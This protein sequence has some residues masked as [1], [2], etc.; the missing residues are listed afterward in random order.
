LLAKKLDAK[1]RI[2]VPVIVRGEEE[3]GVRLWQFGKLVYEMADLSEGNHLIDLS[4]LEEGVYF[5]HPS[6][7]PKR[8][9][10]GKR[11]YNKVKKY[12]FKLYP[13]RKKMIKKPTYVNTNWLALLAMVEE[14]I[15]N[16]TL[17]K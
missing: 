5:I 17:Q 3:K 1:N 16:N 6:E 11:E 13:K 15:L 8:D 12:Y 2:F 4:N 7:V 14:Y 10:V 9:K